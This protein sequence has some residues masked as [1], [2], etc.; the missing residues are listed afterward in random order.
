MQS[1][2]TTPRS[3]SLYGVA[4]QQFAECIALTALASRYSKSLATEE[5]QLLKAIKDSAKRLDINLPVLLN[6]MRIECGPSP[7]S[8]TPLDAERHS[9]LA[10]GYLVDL[11]TEST[12][13]N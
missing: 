11:A 8:H 5:A 3:N 7:K 4:R 2:A 1:A 9:L 10:A 13:K 6:Q 12:A